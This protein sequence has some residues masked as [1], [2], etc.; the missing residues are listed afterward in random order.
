MTTQT[1]SPARELP[2]PNGTITARFYRATR[3]LADAETFAR[4]L[5]GERAAAIADLRDDYG[6]SV[7]DIAMMTGLTEQRVHQLAT[8]GRTYIAS[9]QIERTL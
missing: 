8:A 6:I 2:D 7:A 9:V 3:M 1:V 4:Q 5:R